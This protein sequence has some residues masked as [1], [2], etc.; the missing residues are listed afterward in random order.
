MESASA[1]RTAPL[2]PGRF[3][4]NEIPTTSN[5]R[6]LNLSCN[7]LRSGIERRHGGHQVAQK[8]TSTTLPSKLSPI[9]RITA[10]IRQ[11][12]TGSFASQGT[13]SLRRRSPDSDSADPCFLNS[14]LLSDEQEPISSIDAATAAKIARTRR[15]LVTSF[16]P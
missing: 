7:S 12:K 1:R 13:E 14:A 2:F 9:D 8:S 16:P 3:W 10:Q 6:S 5:P 11:R 4:S 15:S